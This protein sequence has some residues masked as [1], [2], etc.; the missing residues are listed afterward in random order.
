MGYEGRTRTK[1][2]CQTQSSKGDRYGLCGIYSINNAMQER[3]FLTQADLKQCLEKIKESRGDEDHGH[4]VY[5]GYSIQILNMGLNL[6]GRQLLKLN[7]T[8]TFRVAKKHFATKVARSKW[9]RMMVVGYVAG[10]KA[11]CLH[12]M[13]I[14]KVGNVRYLISPD[15][16]WMR[17]CTKK[18]LAGVFSSISLVYAIVEQD[19]KI[20]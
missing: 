12:A 19:V 4:A 9:D 3:D 15:E 14:V 17:V 10:G 6:K 7:R 2:M 18:L 5:G 11:D 13:A 1:P 8:P 20:S 16:Y